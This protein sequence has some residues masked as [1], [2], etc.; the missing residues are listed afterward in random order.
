MPGAGLSLF[1]NEQ[2]P[3]DGE[4]HECEEEDEEGEIL[5]GEHHTNGTILHGVQNSHR[6]P[7]AE[8]NRALAP[9]G[10]SRA[11]RRNPFPCL[12][13]CSRPGTRIPYGYDLPERAMS[14]MGPPVVFRS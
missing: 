14:D 12:T 1:Q 9:K 7:G 10:A 5:D 4:L 11:G 6:A 8:T 3:I 13:T 2:K